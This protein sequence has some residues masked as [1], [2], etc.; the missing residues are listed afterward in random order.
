MVRAV[1]GVIVAAALLGHG[2][3]HLAAQVVHGT[4]MHAGTRFPIQ[5]VAITLRTREGRVLVTTVTDTAGSFRVHSP[6][7]GSYEIVGERIGFTTVKAPLTVNISEQVEIELRMDVTAVAL[8]PLMVKAREHYNLGMLAGYYER[9]QR[10]ERLGVGTFLTRDQ[11]RERQ[12]I[13]TADLLRVTPR[14]VVNNDR[15]GLGPF[16]TLRSGL[17]EC[18]PRVFLNGTL[19]NRNDRAYVDGIIQPEDLEGVEIYQGYTELPGI[20]HDVSGCGVI[21][22]WTNRGDGPGARPFNWK[23]VVGALG[24][25][26]LVVLIAR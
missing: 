26:A 16:I 21:L 12:A 4:V 22:L 17:G 25:A 3:D 7:T 1:L 9:M 14:I 23:R 2:E 8:E 18:H 24:L 15:S 10:N 6:R 13:D 20:Y 19:A 11:I 5:D